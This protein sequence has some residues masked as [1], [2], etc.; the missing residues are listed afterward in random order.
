MKATEQN[1][2][3]VFIIL[4][5]TINMIGVGLA[6]PVLPKLIQQL[7]AGD[8]SNASYIYA[9]IGAL[10]AVSQ[11]LFSPLLGSLSDRFGRKPVLI[12]SL[13]GLGF[14]YFLTALAPGYIWLAIVRFVGGIFAATVTTANAYAADISTP[15]NRARNFGFIGA[16]FGVGFILGPLIG[17]WLGD[18]DVRYPFFAA[19]GL[20]LL[21]ALFGWI[22]LPES[23][24]KEKR[25]PFV[26]SEANPF[27]ALRRMASFPS[28]T[29]LLISLFITATAQRGLEATW[30]L[31][32]EFRFGWGIR[33]AA[34]SLTF[35][36]VMYFII[37]GFAVG[38]IVKRFGE[39]TTMIAGFGIAGISFFFYAIADVGWMVYP[40]IALYAIGNG[41]AAPALNAIC[42]KTV[43][44][45]RQGQLQGALQS[46]NALAFIIGPFLASLI[47][48]HVS[49]ENPLIDLPGAWFVLSGT[50]FGIALWLTL[51]ANQ[52][53]N[54]S[55]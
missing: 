41:I 43:E 35:V 53:Q 13:V 3:M 19:A 23:L 26:L 48:G 21:N 55:Q 36:G 17:G 30:V 6:W 54:A 52:E 4:T 31:Y 29:T 34:W 49:S 7:G 10:F 9:V 12:V 47:L 24:E 50:V 40:L 15:E 51:R 18:I 27:K 42:S 8:V 14:D 16:A 32:T 22:I 39:W 11:F 33:A 20:A 2:S 37:Q 28:L 44:E 38:P 46:V 1:R 45:N 25:R 5:V